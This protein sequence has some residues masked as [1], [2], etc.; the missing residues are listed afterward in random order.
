M[1]VE[2]RAVVAFLPFRS[3]TRHLAFDSAG[4]RVQT[5]LGAAAVCALRWSIFAAAVW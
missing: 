4:N 2:A 1:Q 3:R 5:P